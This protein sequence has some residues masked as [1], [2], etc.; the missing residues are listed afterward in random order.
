MAS[1]IGDHCVVDGGIIKHA[2]DVCPTTPGDA[3]SA[4]DG[5]EEMYPPAHSGTVA[6]DDECK[7]HVVYGVSPCQPDGVF[8]L[9]LTLTSR[10]TGMPVTGAMP[11]IEADLDGHPLPNPAPVAT[12]VGMGEYKISGVRF[13]MEGAWTVRFHFFEMCLETDE[14]TKH[15]HVA[16]TVIVQ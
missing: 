1:G 13:D 6:D 11:S 16:F 4:G 2:A 8:T 12:E 3:A 15:G 10:V 14:N 9:N 7:Y 5:G